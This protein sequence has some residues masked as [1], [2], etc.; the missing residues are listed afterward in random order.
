MNCSELGNRLDRESL[1]SDVDRGEVA[2]VYNSG[3]CDG[4][5]L[6]S[7]RLTVIHSTFYHPPKWMLN[8]GAQWIPTIHD[9]RPVD[10]P[11][12]CENRHIELFIRMG[13]VVAQHS[14]YVHCVSSYSESRIRDLW[15]IPA[16]RTRVIHPAVPLV[17]ESKLY[18]DNEVSSLKPFILF[19]GTVQPAKDLDTAISAFEYAT[20]CLGLL[21]TRLVVA[22][23]DIQHEP[24][25][26]TWNQL[27]T[28]GKVIR[29]KRVSDSKRQSLISMASAVLCTSRYEGF[30]FVPLEAIALGTP[31]I[32]SNAY[33]CLEMIPNWPYT[34]QSGDVVACA[35]VL[36]SVMARQA[37]NQGELHTTFM[38]MLKW[39]WHDVASHF[40]S[41]YRDASNKIAEQRH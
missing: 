7:V 38:Q 13:K 5:D 24:N 2:A 41:L 40:A 22:G 12:S 32:I 8:L 35:K 34:F 10:D 3:R 26:N 15:K 1:N 29:L 20:N 23:S 17:K 18:V 4:I 6:H 21:G 36:E 39:N 9:L 27:L 25:S 11:N 31:P 28:D 14:S 33:P 30:G 19:L 16:S 37:K